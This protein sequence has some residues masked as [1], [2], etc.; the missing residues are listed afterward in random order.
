MV[1]QRRSR[2]AR[3]VWSVPGQI[4]GTAPSRRARGPPIVGPEDRGACANPRPASKAYTVVSGMASAHS[5][6]GWAPTFHPVSSASPPDL[7]RSS[8]TAH[9]RSA[10]TGARRAGRR[11]RGRRGDREPEMSP[12]ATRDPAEGQATLFIQ[13]HGQRHRLRSELRAAPRASEVCSGCWPCTRRRQ[14]AVAHGDT[15]LMDDGAL[16]R[17]IFVILRGVAVR[18]ATA[19]AGHAAG[20]GTCALIDV[21]GA[22]S[23]R[24][25]AVGGAGFAAR[26]RGMRLGRSAG[27]RRRLTI[28]APAR[29]SSSSSSRSFSRRKRWRSSSDRFRS[30]SSRSM[31]AVPDRQ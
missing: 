19:T 22:G 1:R 24:L 4:G 28:R 20:S 16:D 13:D 8:R 23:M 5:Q 15:K 21:T 6:Y 29:L 27:E 25:A 12:A 14:T 7:P 3:H 30:S 9:R 2:W 10:A 26:P 18:R 17:E 11:G 31:S